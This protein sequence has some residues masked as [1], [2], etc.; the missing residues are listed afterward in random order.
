MKA[1]KWEALPDGGW[2]AALD[3]FDA[4]KANL[5]RN[6]KPRPKPDTITLMDL[7]KPVS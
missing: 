5:Y 4:E 1:G 7:C 6:R 3:R 2:R